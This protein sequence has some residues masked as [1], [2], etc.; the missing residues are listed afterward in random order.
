MSTAQRS[1]QGQQGFT[2][3]ELIIIIVILGILAAVAVPQFID[4]K[5]DAEKAAAN[6]VWGGVQGA[7]AINFAAALTNKTQP[8]GGPIANSDTLAA[9]LDGGLPSGWIKGKTDATCI[10]GKG[11]ICID[12]SVDEE[13]TTAD[14]Y[15]ISITT[16]ETTTNKAVLAKN[17]N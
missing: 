2:L 6:G 8:A 5:S 7:A 4:L 15:V 9:S 10:G 12:S 17:W 13:C 16:A 11:C 3:I 1:T 14:T